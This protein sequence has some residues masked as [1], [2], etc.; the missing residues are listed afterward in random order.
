MLS[1][2][3]IKNFP[4]H[5]LVFLLSTLAMIGLGIAGFCVPPI[6]E[7][8]PTVWQYGC[9]LCVP[10]SVSQIR[11]IIREARHLQHFKTSI[12]KVT[13]ETENDE[14][15]EDDNPLPGADKC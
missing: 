9:L 11:P 1:K 4:V 10:L 5:S 15:E 13:I 14:A 3:T 7:I 2:F 12:G 8:S 6:G